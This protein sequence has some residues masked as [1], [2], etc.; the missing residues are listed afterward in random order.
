MPNFR[1]VFMMRFF[2]LIPDEEK[3]WPP[4]DTSPFSRVIIA[5]D[6]KMAEKIADAM[7]GEEVYADER[8]SRVLSV[9]ETEEEPDI[10]SFDDGS[11]TWQQ[12]LK[13]L[14]LKKTDIKFALACG[15]K[16]GIRI[17]NRK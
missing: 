14:G 12:T 9:R 6:Q 7:I 17:K 3:G 5:D 10:V 16:V 11:N 8:L 15:K 4:F 1:L 2:G 13:K